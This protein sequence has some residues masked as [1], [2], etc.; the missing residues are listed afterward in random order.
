MGEE[1]PNGTAAFH[2]TPA[3]GPNSTGSP[4]D[5]ASTPL[6]FGPRKPGQSAAMRI[7]EETKRARGRRCVAGVT[8]NIM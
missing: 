2:A 3:D 6:P 1:R 5:E 7:A 8:L 4:D